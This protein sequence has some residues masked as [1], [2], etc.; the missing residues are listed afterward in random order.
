MVISGNGYVA[1]IIIQEHKFMRTGDLMFPS[2]VV[3]VTGLDPDATYS[4]KMEIVPADTHA[5]ATVAADVRTHMY[6]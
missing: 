5:Q 6:C 4:L 3:N 1:M 2:P